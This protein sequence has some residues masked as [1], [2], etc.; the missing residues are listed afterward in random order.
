MTHSI[1]EMRENPTHSDPG[2]WA[3][4]FPCRL[5][6]GIQA[7]ET[8]IATVREFFQR[9]FKEI[10]AASIAEGGFS[11][12]PESWAEKEGFYSRHAD[13]FRFHDEGRTVGV[14][15]GNALDWSTYYLRHVSFLPSHQGQGHFQEFFARFLEALAARGMERA[16]AHVSPANLANIHILTKLGFTV[17]GYELSERWGANVCLTKFLTQRSLEAFLKQFCW[18]TKPQLQH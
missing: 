4:F 16:Q 12:L 13:L 7:E 3:P 9:H 2:T 15:V 17:T 10:Y 18:G 5:S 6:G 11:P 8:S 14:Y 1:S